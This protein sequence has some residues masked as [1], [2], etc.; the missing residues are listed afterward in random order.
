MIEEPVVLGITGTTTGRIT[1]HDT[2][3]MIG[4]GIAVAKAR[5][6]NFTV[7]NGMVRQRRR[8]NVK[9]VC[10]YIGKMGEKRGSWTKAAM[11]TEQ[12]R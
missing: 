4:D 6:L 1:N 2:E 9:G 12:R 11:R 5:G 3:R 10:L 7:K 8:G